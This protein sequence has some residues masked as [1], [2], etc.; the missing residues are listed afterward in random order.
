MCKGVIVPGGIFRNCKGETL[1]Y[2]QAV[3]EHAKCCDGISCCKHELYLTDKTTNER[4]VIDVDNGNL[5]LEGSAITGATG[6][7]GANGR[8]VELSVQ[9]STELSWRYVGDPSWTLLIDL[10]TLP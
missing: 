5:R 10:S 3:E 8:E 1:S 7:A 9:N 2:E 4:T 6:P